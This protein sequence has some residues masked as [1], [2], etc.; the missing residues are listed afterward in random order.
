MAHPSPQTVYDNLALLE[1]VDTARSAQY[2]EFAQE[3]LADETV[4]LRWRTAI[5]ERLNH[6][7]QRL[8]VQNLFGYDSY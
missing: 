4:S 2:R 6:A 1:Q 7:N 5:A 8:A 3:V